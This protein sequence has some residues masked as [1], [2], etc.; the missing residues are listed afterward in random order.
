VARP[1]TNSKKI[2][3]T[4]PAG[5]LALLDQLVDRKL[6]GESRSEIARHLIISALDELVEK[7]RLTEPPELARG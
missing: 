6:Y 2:G 3:I 7:R 4:L 1:K 5:A